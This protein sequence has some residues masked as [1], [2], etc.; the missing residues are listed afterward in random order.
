MCVCMCSY[1]L[2]KCSKTYSLYSCFR[3]LYSNCGSIKMS[4][5][6]GSL[7]QNGCSRTWTTSFMP[8]PRISSPG[9]QLGS[10]LDTHSTHVKCLITRIEAWKLRAPWRWNAHTLP[11]SEAWDG[12]SRKA[13]VTANSTLVEPSSPE[14][15][16]DAKPWQIQNKIHNN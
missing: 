8:G 3:Q 10:K 7:T 12:R 9:N 1:I 14:C 16:R 13:W 2:L 15:A 5:S 6:Y 4:R 11:I